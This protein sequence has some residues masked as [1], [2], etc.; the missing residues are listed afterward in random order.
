MVI[1]RD[2]VASD[3][4]VYAWPFPIGPEP[5]EVAC[6][7]DEIV[8]M[9]P[10]WIVTDRLGPGRHHWRTPDPSK[11]TNAFFVLTGPVEAPF[12]MVTTFVVPSTQQPV[13]LARRAA[14]SC[15]AWIPRC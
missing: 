6:Q 13:R 10:A 3:Q 14:C 9:C 15:A 8:V 5:I 7:Q 4:L 11:P 2:T 12:D 1:A